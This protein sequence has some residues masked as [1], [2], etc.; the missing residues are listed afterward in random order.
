MKTKQQ[1]AR[2][3]NQGM[4]WI[5]QDK[6]LAIY[7]RDGLCCAYCGESVEKNTQ[8]TFKL[9]LDHLVCVTHG[10]SNSEGN[11]ITSCMRCNSQRSDMI[12]EDWLVKKCGDDAASVARFIVS[13]TGLNLK[14]YRKEAKEIIARRK[15]AKAAK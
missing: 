7:L 2:K 1:I 13:H 5:R 3:K 4:N 14:P 8:D 11:L 10:G 6:R 12:L 9:S 15:A